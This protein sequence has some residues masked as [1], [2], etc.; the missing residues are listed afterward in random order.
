MKG[1]QEVVEVYQKVFGKASKEIEFVGS[2]GWCHGYS[3]TTSLFLRHVLRPKVLHFVDTVDS[4]K[5]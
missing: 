4:D 3:Q 1:G 5:V 2:G